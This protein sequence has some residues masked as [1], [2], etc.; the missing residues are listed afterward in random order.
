MTNIKNLHGEIITEE[1]FN[2]VWENE[3]VSNIECFGDSSVNPGCEL[4]CVELID[5]TEIDLHVRK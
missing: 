5:G 1:K 4:F 2:E 3:N